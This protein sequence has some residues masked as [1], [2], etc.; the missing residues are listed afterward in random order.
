MS[1]SFFHP[2]G[3]HRCP[4]KSDQSFCL[5]KVK[6]LLICIFCW[7]FNKIFF[8]YTPDVLPTLGWV[9]RLWTAAPASASFV[10]RARG[11]G[12]RSGAEGAR[13]VRPG[14]A[15]RGEH[16]LATEGRDRGN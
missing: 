15:W 4:D 16:W 11:P 14:Y 7:L 9:S 10:T 1:L 8:R 6:K 2:D 12:E 3:A 5:H 13:G